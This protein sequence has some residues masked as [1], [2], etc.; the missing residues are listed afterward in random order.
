MYHPSFSP[1]RDDLVAFR[2]LF[3]PFPS[4][5][6]RACVC[7]QILPSSPRL[8]VRAP[9]DARRRRRVASIEHPFRRRRRRDPR[10]CRSFSSRFS[11]RVDVLFS[12]TAGSIHPTR[13]MSMSRRSLPWPL[14]FARRLATPRASRGVARGA[15]LAPRRRRRKP[16]RETTNSPPPPR[17]RARRPRAPRRAP[18][19]VAAVAPRARP[20]P[21][22]PRARPRRRPARA[23]RASRASPPPPSSTL[24][25]P[26]PS[27]ARRRARRSS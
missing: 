17:P 13:S 7:A 10:E 21:H 25:P 1:S 22:R 15:P 12:P 14:S 18:R 16:A 20:E 19:L 11:P 24:R 5:R 6:A 9:L 4:R 2:F 27:T 3:H 26:P 23:R 8:F